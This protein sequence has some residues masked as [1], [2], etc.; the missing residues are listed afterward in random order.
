MF[1]RLSMKANLLHRAKRTDSTLRRANCTLIAPSRF[2]NHHIQ[3]RAFYALPYL[4]GIVSLQKHKSVPQPSDPTPTEIMKANARSPIS[5]PKKA[6]RILPAS[7]ERY[8]PKFRVNS[9]PFCW[10]TNYL[11]SKFKWF[12]LSPKSLQSPSKTVIGI[13]TMHGK[14]L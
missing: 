8:T 12:P 11:C 4:S 2:F 10:Q 1:S 9:S 3:K 7:P 13:S 5:L 6:A 14:I